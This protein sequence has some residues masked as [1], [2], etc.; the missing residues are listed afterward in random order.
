MIPYVTAGL[1]E[2]WNRAG[3]LLEDA[4]DITWQVP[5]IPGAQ[6]I[7]EVGHEDVNATS[8]VHVI[9]AGPRFPTDRSDGAP[10]DAYAPIDPGGDAAKAF[11]PLISTGE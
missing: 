4:P 7:I 1:G 3:T 2:E 9:S 11:L 8:G 6:V 10:D 5:V